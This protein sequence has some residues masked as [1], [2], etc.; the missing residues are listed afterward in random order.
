MSMQ[1]MA[2]DAPM[3]V[4]RALVSSAFKAEGGEQALWAWRGGIYQWDGSAW[5]YRSEDWLRKA[6]WH[7]LEDATFNKQ[8]AQGMAVVRYE[9]TKRKVEDVAAALSTLTLLEMDEV[10]SWLDGGDGAPEAGMVVP[11]RNMMVDVTE[12]ARR[13]RETGTY[14]WATLNVNPKLFTR[15]ALTVNF[16]PHH[17][18]PVWT[19]KMGQWSGGDPQWVEL[20]ERVFG[21]AMVGSRKY[22]K[23]LLEYGK[24]RGGKGSGTGVLGQLMPRPAYFGIQMRA[25]ASEF[26]MDGL[27]TASVAVISEVNDEGERAQEAIGSTI[28]LMLGGD[29]C[30]INAKYQRQRKHVTLR[31]LPIVQGNNMLRLPNKGMG[32]SSK[33]LALP[34]DYSWYGKEDWDLPKK[35]KGELTGIAVRLMK[36]L[37]RLEAEQETTKKF[38]MGER[39]LELIKQ[40]EHEANP[41]DWFLETNFVRA[42][43]GFVHGELIR[44]L[45]VDWETRT[46]IVLKTDSG[47][48][49]SDQNLLQQIE[50]HA[51]WLVR[52]D[53]LNTATG[54]GSRGMTGLSLRKVVK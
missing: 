35:L 51:S 25:L 7:A 29:E 22:P 21:Y 17:E 39:S 24:A 33:M 19:E 28:K 14:D 3:K 34:F 4:A 43:G 26:G 20:R 52:R 45:R 48:R 54:G 30:T 46:G 37:V 5:I 23:W 38:E 40:F 44:Q 27:D 8:T 10:P 36:A 6:V 41:Y 42:Q 31:V 50:K 32:V 12:T 2:S 9:P 1:N 53:R 16:E 15:S 47:D 13:F 49:V 18:C 11:F